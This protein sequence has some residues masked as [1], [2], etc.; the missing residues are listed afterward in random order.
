M[1]EAIN[2][3]ESNR[4]KSARFFGRVLTCLVFGSC[5]AI[6]QSNSPS[7]QP[8]STNWLDRLLRI[9]VPKS[10]TFV[11]VQQAPSNC[12]VA[13]LAGIWEP[14]AA[15]FEASVGTMA[16]VDTS[17]LTEAAASA[18]ARLQ[19]LVA[20]IGGRLELKSAYRPPAY[21]EH[22]QA[23]W[24]K[25]KSLRYNRQAG[26]KVL[27]AEVESEFKRHNLLPSQRP[28]SDSDHTRGIGIDA[29]VTIPRGARLQRRRL[30]LDRLIQMV[31][32]KRPDIRHDPVHFRLLA[33]APAASGALHSTP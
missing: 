25:W 7:P 24:D 26:C 18:L 5:L 32:F 33:S 2:L 30:T 23:V 21:Q 8:D 9:P 1:R 22:L 19:E 14:G 29:S 4:L 13:P 16:V 27:R 6:A 10:P 20:S 17:G 12:S 28:V 11:P 31:G 3:Q 15:S